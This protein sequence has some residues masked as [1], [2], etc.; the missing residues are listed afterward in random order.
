M[1]TQI[2]LEAALRSL[3]MGVTIW[4][5][6]RLLRIRQ[7]RAQRT[8][9]LLALIG[10]LAMPALV[11]WQVGPR[12][13]PAAAPI[14]A[15]RDDSASI[16][17]M[18]DSLPE[19]VQA[20]PAA[21]QVTAARNI[22]MAPALSFASLSAA[23]VVLYLMVA[24]VLMV[25]LGTGIGFALRLRR[26]AQPVASP[27]APQSDIRVSDRIASP[28]TIASTVLLPT[29]CSSWDEATL[30]VVL[31]HESAHVRQRD[32][33]V[34]LL[35]GLHCALFWFN[36]FSWWLQ[37]QLSE[38]GEALSDRAAVEHAESRASYAEMLLAFATRGRWP[39]AGVAMARSS[40]LT[41][42][43][44]RL[45]N[46][47]GFEQSFETRQR[48]PFVAAVIVAFAMIA[49]TTTVKVRADE[50]SQTVSPDNESILSIH[51]GDSTVTV[52]SGAKLP[53]LQGD[54]IALNPAN[55]SVLAI[56]SG[57]SRVAFDWGDKLPPQGDYIYYQH[58]GKTYVIQDP[59][60]L[61]KAQSLLAP[62]HQIRQKQRELG[63]EQAQLGK[64]QALLEKQQRAFVKDPS[65]KDLVVKVDTPEFKQSMAELDKVIRQMDLSHLTVEIDQKALAQLQAHLGEMQGR[66]AEVEAEL[67]AKNLKFGEEQGALGEQ[68]GE[69]GEQQ[70]RLGERQRLL[71][72]E[73]RKMIEDATSKLKPIIEQAIRDG[74]A[75]PFV[76]M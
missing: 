1:S 14:S 32:F 48:L 63:K 27:F 13:L 38:L 17:A 55:K 75:M 66:I 35:A 61:A 42:R 52:A 56:Q 49:S 15:A 53:R 25:R 24:G 29:A 37:R 30:R 5:A 8:A 31:T 51:D 69:L 46:D 41:P 19:S 6:L 72:E 45:L 50:S 18:H 23:A 64:Q 11:G 16:F 7:V 65:L 4:A 67:A 47:S 34:Q 26:R 71:G 40:G 12:L 9:W 3:I 58:D 43:I 2:L 28:V 70:R 54:Y 62:M 60:T 10:A 59:N 20:M 73:Q 39:Q 44:E 74:T 68:Q 33:Y 36:P 76:P 57:D 21:L 22:S